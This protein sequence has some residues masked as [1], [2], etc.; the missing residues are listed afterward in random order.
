MEFIASGGK[1]QLI[2][3]TSTVSGEGKTFIAVNL[4]AICAYAGQKVVVVDLDMRK[5]KVHLAFESERQAKG[6]S[7][8]L[9][10]KEKLDDCILPSE[11]ENLSFIPAGPTPP[12]P[13]ELLLS[14]KFDEFIA[15]L[16]SKFDVIFLDSPPVG[17][18]TDGILIMKKADLPIYV[19]RAEYSK[20]SYLKSV[21]RLVS[22]NKFEHLSV[23]LNGVSSGKGGGYGYGYGYGY[24]D[25]YYEE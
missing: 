24:D 23:I 5:P 18:V 25:S 16:R 12:N 11:L 6:M 9:I 21:H 19:V 4:G 10:G 3:V 13:S 14:P 8:Y 15:D 2:S 17:L 22:N 20:K 7:T 1:N